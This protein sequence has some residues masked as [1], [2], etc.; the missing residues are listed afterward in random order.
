[1]LQSIRPFVG[2]MAESVVL[3]LFDDVE[4]FYNRRGNGFITCDIA[5]RY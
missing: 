3:A 5:A 1:M 2:N 4:S